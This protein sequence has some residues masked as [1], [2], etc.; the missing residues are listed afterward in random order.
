MKRLHTLKSGIC[1]HASGKTLLLPASSA[2][3]FASAF[4][5][6]L[7]ALRKSYSLIVE[8]G[9]R[10]MEWKFVITLCVELL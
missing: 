10:I 2:I 8:F 1:L 6:K 3:R 5:T 7:T 9:K 4:H